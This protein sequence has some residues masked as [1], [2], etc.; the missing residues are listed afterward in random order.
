MA[1]RVIQNLVEQ[2]V[3]VEGENA[4]VGVLL[5]QRSGKI[6][7]ALVEVGNADAFEVDAVGSLGDGERGALDGWDVQEKEV[8]GT[9]RVKLRRVN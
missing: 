9:T 2:A 1:G 4:G 6:R 8:A 7:N 5:T 3:G